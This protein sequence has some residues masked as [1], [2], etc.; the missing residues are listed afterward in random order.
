M[1]AG[2]TST[3]TVNNSENHVSAGNL[4]QAVYKYFNL[5]FRG[6][7]KLYWIDNFK[8]KS[9]QRDPATDMLIEILLK[10][11]KKVVSKKR[12]KGVRGFKVKCEDREGRRHQL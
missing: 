10:F 12:G 5:I 9:A 7:L 3:T 8:T 2:T 4:F 11:T 1:E 6:V